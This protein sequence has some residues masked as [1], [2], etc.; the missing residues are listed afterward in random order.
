M[1]SI[2]RLSIL[3]L[4]V[5]LCLGLLPVTASAV[6]QQ[7]AVS[8]A[9]NQI[10][11][12]IDYDGKYGVQC[13]DF[14]MK[15]CKQL[16]NVSMG[17]NARD[18]RTNKLPSGWTRTKYTA[19]YVP[20]P[21]DIIIYTP[22]YVKGSRKISSFG[23]VSIIL[24]AT[25]SGYVCASQKAHDKINKVSRNNYDDVW[26][27]IHPAYSGGGN[28]VIETTDP[29]S[30]TFSN[31]QARKVTN[32]SAE[33]Y[34]TVE[35]SGAKVTEVGMYIGLSKENMTKLGSDNGKAGYKKN[36]W[37]NTTKYSYPL[38]EGT[39]YYYQPYAV[40][41]GKT[42]KGNINSFTT[43]G[44]KKTPV[45]ASGSTSTST[46]SGGDCSSGNHV[47][48]DW[49]VTQ[50]EHP[51]YVTWKCTKCGQFIGD[52]TKTTLATCVL[53][54][55]EAPITFSN[56]QVRKLTSTSAEPY[57]TATAKSGK[58]ARVGMYIGADKNNMTQLGTDNG[59]PKP[60]KN[61]WYN[62]TK[63]NY[64]LKPGTTYYY[65]PFAE[66]NGM[67]YYGEIKSFTTPTK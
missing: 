50:R 28:S 17:G 65:Q 33:P 36:M 34:A 35:S 27:F 56:Y 40:V 7:E 41:G 15:Y 21:G 37:Y 9:Q 23:H 58:V 3:F 55:P 25:S 8:W 20:Q 61:M 30:V 19:G 62:T 67:N 29:I 52:G 66:V 18:Y 43:D 42:Y 24:S 64:P 38:V 10:G 63:Y 31:Y 39:T 14:I 12:S 1:K 32:T 59:T 6:S 49:R 26:G 44:V 47:K 5:A 46:S 13:V 16:F 2:K 53:C 45:T 51:H 60:L 22:G 11:K 57:A 4:T 48:G 54:H